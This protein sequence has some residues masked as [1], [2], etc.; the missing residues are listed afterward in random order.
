MTEVACLQWELTFDSFMFLVRVSFF[1]YFFM[2]STWKVFS[3]G[4]VSL[5]LC[6][7]NCDA[8]VSP[9]STVAHCGLKFSQSNHSYRQTLFVQWVLMFV[10]HYLSLSLSYLKLLNNLY[11]SIVEYALVAIAQSIVRMCVVHTGS[12]I[13]N[14]RICFFICT[15]EKKNPSLDVID[16]HKLHT[17]N[18]WL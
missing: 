1:F 10:F 3:I 8:T 6:G 9:I 7:I 5:S 16:A 4:S 2:A 17:Q 13:N 11:C 15:R 12:T 18:L 14:R